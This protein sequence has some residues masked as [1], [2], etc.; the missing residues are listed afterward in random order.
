MKKLY[1]YYFVTVGYGEYLKYS[2]D[3]YKL[4][5]YMFVDSTGLDDTKIDCKVYETFTPTCWQ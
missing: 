3:E 5:L 2:N 4:Q 1:S